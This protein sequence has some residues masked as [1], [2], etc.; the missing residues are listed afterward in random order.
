MKKFLIVWLALLAA[1]P[2]CYGAIHLTVQIMIA[3][4]IGAA[5][6]LT[7]WFAAAIA[8]MDWC[9]TAERDQ[10]RKEMSE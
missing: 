2:I 5:I 1:V 6:I 9:L 7:F 3:S 10:R 8:A 4:K